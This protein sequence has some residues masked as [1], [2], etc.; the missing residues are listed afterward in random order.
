MS[1]DTPI[2]TLM[3]RYLSTVKRG[4]REGTSELEVKFGT[5]RNAEPITKKSQEDVVRKFMSMGFTPTK[6]V[7]YLRVS[8]LRGDPA[9][10]EIS[11]LNAVSKYCQTNDPA[12]VMS[13]GAAQLVSKTSDV[14]PVDVAAFGFRVALSTERVLDQTGT[15]LEDWDSKPKIFR[16]IKRTT[17]RS[18]DYPFIL[19]ASVVRQ[20]AGA[21]TLTFQDAKL[22]EKNKRYELE[23]EVDPLQVGVGTKYD[24]GAHLYAHLRTLIVAVLSGVQ[25]SNFPISTQ[26]RSGVRE[27]YCSLV[28]LAKDRCMFIGPSPIS[29]QVNNIAPISDNA[30]IPNIRENYTVTDKADGARKLLYVAESGRMYLID[31]NLVIQFTGAQST[32]SELFNSLFDGEHIE[33]AKDGSFIN[34][35]AAFDVYFIGK[36]DVRGQPFTGE[37]NEGTRLLLMTEAMNGLGI[38][39]V[40]PGTPA[41]FT[42]R[43]KTF[44]RASTG[45][46][47]FSASKHVLERGRELEYETDGLIYTPASLGVGCDASSAKGKSSR[48]TWEHAFKWKPPEY[49]TID[50]LISFEKEA[51]GRDKVS[52]LFQGGLNTRKA[53]QGTSYKT[54]ILKVG[55]DSRKHGYINPCETMLSGKW[56]TDT[57]GSQ[58]RPVQFF[59]T[60][61][62]DDDTGIC[63][64]SL[65]QAS[66]G[67]E[68]VMAED[69]DTVEDN[70]IVEFS[71]DI[72][73]EQGWQ[74]KPIRVRHDKT[75]ELRKGGRNYGNAYHVANSN[76][77]SIHNPVTE[78]MITTGA[79]IPDE[80]ATDGIYYSRLGRGALTKGLRD[81]HNLWVKRE[82]IV[83]MS[84]PG[85]TLIDLACGKAGDLPKWIAAKL[86]FV[87]GIDLSPDNIDNRLD[88]ACARYLNYRRKMRN[89]PSAFF[90]A[91]NSVLNIRDGTGIEG[92]T[93][94]T[95]N[96]AVFGIETS[97][98]PPPQVLK[99]RGIARNGFDIC[100]LQFAI[101]YMFK[102]ARTLNGCLRNVSEV[103][104]TGG[105]FVGT[106]YDGARVFSMLANTEVGKSQT[107]TKQGTRIWQ[108]TKQYSEQSF[109][110]GPAS[111]GLA[112]DVYQ[113]SIGKTTREYLVN[114]TYLKQALEAYGFQPADAADLQEAGISTPIGNFGIMFEDMLRQVKTNP[115]LKSRLGAA[116]G[117]STDE[118]QISFLN[119]YFIFKKVRDVDAA[120]VARSR[121]GETM[122]QQEAQEKATAE[123]GRAVEEAEAKTA[124]NKPTFTKLG[125]RIKLVVKQSTK[126]ST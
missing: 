125:R 59:P 92:S 74:W 107:I 58:Y 87:Y 120:A 101:H 35:F 86:K 32:T 114:M 102:D 123:T 33:N 1:S 65:T 11:S 82:L 3:D 14:A 39:A 6:E 72:D 63:N 13:T 31:T 40:I 54:A 95:V 50:F 25:G 42:C 20:S 119:T 5:M 124:S 79:G 96:A 38:E 30:L 66:N 67:D 4:G 77:H 26:E 109:K 71:F 62:S 43:A 70:T 49:N 48:R 28:G 91:G 55:F 23:V 45:N 2:A 61:P 83:G 100:S 113:D 52:N 84:R 78:A 36:K 121:I 117:M 17:L 44:H 69:G 21:D 90:V 10:L 37:T 103:V 126:T 34:L 110:T 116:M 19:D 9:R 16:L 80:L 105:Y 81:F 15:V 24:T 47:I 46:S 22:A 76:W 60:N 111:L 18:P 27:S 53:I 118:K 122:L 97:G 99:V 57:R 8:S 88:G 73:A 68:L 94:R 64:L 12:S 98:A 29:L 56:D 93:G 41:P 108:V 89:M 85:Q 112:I 75:A 106:C 7:T 104:R 115:K 51:S